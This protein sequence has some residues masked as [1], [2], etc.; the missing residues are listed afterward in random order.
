VS[1]SAADHK[2]V[3]MARSTVTHIS[4]D[5]DGSA[6]AQTV[7]FRFQGVAYSIDL[8]Q[9][10]LDKLTTALTAFIEHATRERRAASQGTSATRVKTAAERGYE[11][12]ELREWAGQ[13]KVALPQRGRIP[14]PIVAQ[15]L[16]AGGR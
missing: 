9:K 15:Y 4:H 3:H 11:L 14:A 16:A 7:T 1:I 12:A 10:N 2:E 13:N 5:I 8:G 6:E